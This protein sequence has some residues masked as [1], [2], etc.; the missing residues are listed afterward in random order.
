M[1]G[2]T[3][4]SRTEVQGRQGT[5]GRGKEVVSTQAAYPSE[6]KVQSDSSFA[7]EPGLR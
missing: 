3:P 1:A 7:F 2:R 5:D 4:P 6:Q